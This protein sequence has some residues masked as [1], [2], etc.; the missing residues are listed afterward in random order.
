MTMNESQLFTHDG[1]DYS[2]TE[3][4]TPSHNR[5]IWVVHDSQNRPVVYAS[6]DEGEEHIHVEP[7]DRPQEAYSVASGLFAL[8]EAGVSVAVKGAL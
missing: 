7:V 3:L 5:R 4:L 2:I 8:N 6:T 1:H